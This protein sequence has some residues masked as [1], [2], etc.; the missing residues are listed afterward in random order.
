MKNGNVFRLSEEELER[1]MRSSQRSSGTRTITRPQA[2]RLPPA[3][4]VNWVLP[5]ALPA[6]RR[7]S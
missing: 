7:R 3:R 2:K 5:I 4:G 6:H 1:W